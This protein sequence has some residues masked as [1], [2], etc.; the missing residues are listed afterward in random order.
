MRRTNRRIVWGAAVVV[1]GLAVA[2]CA[3][4]ASAPGVKIPTGAEAPTAALSDG[5]VV[6][7]AVRDVV[8]VPRFGASADVR[9]LGFGTREA[10]VVG[11][12]AR[13]DANGVLLAL[14]PGHDGEHRDLRHDD[15]EGHSHRLV[16]DGQPGGEGPPVTVRY[17]RDGE[18]VAEVDYRWERRGGG[19]VPSERTLTLYRHG[20]VLLR[21]TRRVYGVEIAAG[22]PATEVPGA[23]SSAPPPSVMRMQAI[24]CLREWATYIGASATMI[25]AGEA[26]T[27][28]PNPTT[29]SALVASFGAWENSLDKLLMC[30]VNSVIGF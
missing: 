2:A 4:D 25:L 11:G 18:V 27:L 20:R 14:G 1:A 22:A 7:A 30:Q 12:V 13:D 19:Y 3:R 15:E 16:L 5:A 29:G 10:V 26:F 17:E 8:E 6:R 21:Q 23:G 24:P 9:E 28:L